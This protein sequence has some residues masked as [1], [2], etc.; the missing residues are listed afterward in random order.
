MVRSMLDLLRDRLEKWC[1]TCP[2]CCLDRDGGKRHDMTDCLRNDTVEIIERSATMQRHIEKCGGFQGTECCS[3]CGVPRAVCQRRHVEAD[4]SWEEVPGQ[5]CQY[6][7]MLIPAVITM[8]MD[9]CNEGW[10]VA[11]SWMDREGVT[12]SS[13][14]EVFE[15]FRQEILWEGIKV[16]RIVR[17]FHML[18]NKNRGVGKS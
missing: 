15:W 2:A 16:A 1:Q 4:G 8:L 7:G 10:A 3:W 11:G 6:Q 9:G 18:V 13:Q 14:T 12:Q 17:V 5:Q